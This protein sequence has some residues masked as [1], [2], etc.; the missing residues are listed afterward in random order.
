MNQL[1]NNL[2]ALIA[3]ISPQLGDVSLYAL[4]EKPSPEKWSKKEIIGHLIDSAC[5]NQQ[6]FVRMTAQPHFDFV[7]YE[8]NHWVAAQA[9]NE[10]D[11]KNL[12]ALWTHY[13]LHLA[14]IIASVRPETLQHTISINGEGLFTL[15]FIMSD[16]VEHLKHH[17]RQILPDAGI[18]SR[19]VNVYHNAN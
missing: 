7:G 16:Y 19:F 14:H 18:D 11:W 6:K 9:Y 15:E 4:H 12:L 8:Q 1:A 2:R 13:N 3:Q 10:A 17:L 5:N